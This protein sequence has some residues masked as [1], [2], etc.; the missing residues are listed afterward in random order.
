MARDEL[1]WLSFFFFLS[2]SGRTKCFCGKK[3]NPYLLFK[4][5][6]HFKFL[7]PYCPLPIAQMPPISRR[8]AAT[9][10]DRVW[11]GPGNRRSRSRPRPH[12]TAASA[13]KPRLYGPLPGTSSWEKEPARR[14][15]KKSPPRA[16]S[17]AGCWHP[18]WSPPASSLERGRQTPRRV[19]P[20]KKAAAP[21]P[22]ASEDDDQTTTVRRLGKME[23]LIPCTLL[24]NL[25]RNY[26]FFYFL[27]CPYLN[28]IRVRAKYLHLGGRRSEPSIHG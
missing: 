23:C 5:D 13:T 28:A 18:F 16:G 20:K 21:F 25:P 12:A 10:P 8:S 4:A 26:S 7:R 11:P 24:S 22:V 9:S 14:T 19:P 17:F 2:A 27:N 3:N 1:N 6:L 15:P